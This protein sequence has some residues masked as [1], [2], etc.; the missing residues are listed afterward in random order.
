[1]SESGEKIK[2]THIQALPG[3]EVL[4]AIPAFKAIVGQFFK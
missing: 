1:M 3:C 4:F 2:T